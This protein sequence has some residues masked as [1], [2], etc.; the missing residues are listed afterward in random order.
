MAIPSSNP[1]TMV[2][3]QFARL[4]SIACVLSLLCAA[5][6]APAQSRARDSRVGQSGVRATPLSFSATLQQCLTSVKQA[7]RSATFSGEMVAGVGTRRMA[8]QINV[9][10]RLRGETLFHTISAPGLGQWRSSEV[11]VKIYKYLKQVTNLQA[12]ASFRGLVRF[13]WFNDRGHVVK[14]AAL[15]TP[16]C[17]QPAT[18]ATEVSTSTTS[19]TPPATPT[20][21]TTA[22]TTSP[23]G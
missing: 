22:T 6:G 2:H 8:M 15:L 21:S 23:T 1:T 11:T 16:R 12:P 10:E 4:A 13:R 20:T 3:S 19:M 17:Q 5:Q 14:H 9:E 18:E 7:E